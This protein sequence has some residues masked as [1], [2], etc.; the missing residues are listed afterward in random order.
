MSYVTQTQKGK[1]AGLTAAIAING[2]II[3][4]IMLSPV[5]LPPKIKDAGFTAVPIDKP[6][7]PAPPPETKQTV[8]QPPIVPPIYAPTPIVP[9]IDPVDPGPTIGDVMADDP[10]PP[11]GSLGEEPKIAAAAEIPKIDPKPPVPIFRAAVRDPRY[12]G[13]FQPDYPRGLLQKEIEGSVTVK[14]LIGT[15]GRVREAMVVRA[16]HPD[17]GAATVK[18]ALESWRFKP[19]TRDGKAVEDWQTLSVR[20]DIN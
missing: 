19:A 10:L 14:V 6:V 17:F 7:P 12:A 20:F 4:A 11:A 8:E 2:A 16:T 13:K 9:M 5:V 3:A 18:K 15:D 1:P